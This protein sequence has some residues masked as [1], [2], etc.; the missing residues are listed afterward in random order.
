[1]FC[2]TCGQQIDFDGNG[3]LIHLTAATFP[4]LNGHDPKL[5]E[6][7]KERIKEREIN[8][9]FNIIVEWLNIQKENRYTGSYVHRLDEEFILDGHF[10]I[11]TLAE[12]IYEGIHK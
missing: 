10:D 9:L 8:K 6:S 7:D 1:L 5:S 2:E 3:L 12:A 11:H 4:F